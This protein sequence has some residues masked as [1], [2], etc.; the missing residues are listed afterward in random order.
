[1]YSLEQSVFGEAHAELLGTLEVLGQIA[2]AKSDFTTEIQYRQRQ[3]T[4]TYKLFD[5]ND[6]RTQDAQRT[7]SQTVH[8]SQ[9]THNQRTE[10]SRADA[11]NQQAVQAYRSGDF[12]TGIRA[13]TECLATRERVLGKEHPS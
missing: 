13:V 10:L 11:F 5:P 9:L 1:L 7:V 6:Y 2:E 3:L 12:V 8:R 4:I